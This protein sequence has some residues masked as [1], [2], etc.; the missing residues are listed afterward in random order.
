MVH[1]GWLI[2]SDMQQR[3]EAIPRSRSPVSMKVHRGAFKNKNDPRERST[4]SL[5]RSDCLKA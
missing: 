3:A 2:A 4:G 1:D 5:L